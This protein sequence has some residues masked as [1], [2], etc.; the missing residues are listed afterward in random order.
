MGN[1]LFGSGQR[2]YLEKMMEQEWGPSTF[3]VGPYLYDDGLD[4]D[5]VLLNIDTDF[6]LFYGNL[7]I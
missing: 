5:L 2:P 4:L 7:E 6:M 3:V 1:R